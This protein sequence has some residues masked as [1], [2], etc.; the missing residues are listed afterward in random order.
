MTTVMQMSPPFIA[1]N[2]TMLNVE[3]ISGSV[4]VGVVVADV[5]MIS[6]VDPQP[7]A[8]VVALTIDVL[9]IEPEFMPEY[10]AT[11]GDEWVEDSTDDQPVIKL[12]GTRFC[13]SE[14]WRNMRLMYQ[15]VGT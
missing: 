5:G 13:C 1:S 7:I 10:N 6:G 11:F 3:P 9:S 2:E 4:G 8:T 12:T 14:H 15:I